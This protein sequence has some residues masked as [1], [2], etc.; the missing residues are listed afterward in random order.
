MA[1]IQEAEAETLRNK[2]TDDSAQLKRLYRSKK[3]DY[4]TR[5]VEHNLV[6]DMVKDGWEEYGKPLVTKTR[7]R[8]LKKHND[9]FED[10]IWCQLYELGYQI[11][12]Y[13]ND[14]HLPYGKNPKERKQ[15]DVI[16][17]NED[18]ILLVE[19]K[20]SHKLS[21]PPSFK[22]EFE[23]LPIRLEGFKKTL[24]QLFGRGKKV[25]YI[26]ATRNLRI[27]HGSTDIERLLDTNS[28]F[29]DDNTY[30]YV[31]SLIDKY[32]DA[33]RYQF[34]AMLFRGQSISK[35]KIEVPAIEGKMGNKTYYMFSIEPHLLLKM[36]FVLHRTKANNEEMPTYQRLLVPS[37]LKGIAKFIE[38]GGYFPNSIILNFD[39]KKNRMHFEPSIKGADSLSK[40]GMLKIPNAYAIAYIIDG[41]HRVYGYAQSPYKE[42]NT[43]PVVA[44]KDLESPEQ[45]KLFMDINENQKAV[46]PTLRITLE[47]DLYWESDRADARMKALRSSV[48]QKLNNDISGPLYGKI[49]IGEDKSDLPAK[50]FSNGLS[51]SGLIPSAKGNKFTPG[52]GSRS[53][54]DTN[55][56]SHD[57][58]MS[59]ARDSITKFINL[60]YQFA[61]D[62]YPNVFDREG[63]FIMSSRGTFAFICLI[64]S[65]NRHKSEQGVVNVATR[66]NDRFDSIKEYLSD[67]LLGISEITKED[68]QRLMRHL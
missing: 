45:L 4:H 59:R 34:L 50:P 9:K 61:S 8:K 58:E 14:F 63:G 10:D 31:K 66:A 15:I 65:L 24:E 11:L 49:S 29:Y 6:E 5:S 40:S 55:N 16:A 20:S 41:Q 56:H 17:I 23:G 54:Y 37:R 22:T 1:F 3:N 60:C 67:T 38:E 33:A 62:N 26:F 28:F 13:S 42:S 48:I 21:K 44:F 35:E 53:L 46:S 68:E 47:E 2:L 36:G 51:Q 18:S 52:S 64:G 12:N 7:L 30:E 43:I 39:T 19:C 27:D 25:K 32:K 57:K